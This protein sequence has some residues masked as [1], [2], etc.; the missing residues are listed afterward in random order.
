MIASVVLTRDVEVGDVVQAGRTMLVVAN[1]GDVELVFQSDERNL[2][3]LA[4]KRGD[5]R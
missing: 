2:A 3:S 1:D 5:W 4:R